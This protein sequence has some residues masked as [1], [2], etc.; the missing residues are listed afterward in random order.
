VRVLESLWLLSTTATVAQISQAI[1]SLI[2][3]DD[4]FAIIE[5]KQGSEWGTLR[6]KREGADWLSNN[7]RR[8]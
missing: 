3:N 8:Y 4:S 1:V 7:I 2:D 5:L 6:A